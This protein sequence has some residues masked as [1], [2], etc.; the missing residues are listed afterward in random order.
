[1]RECGAGRDHDRRQVAG[2]T[3]VLYHRLL[4]GREGGG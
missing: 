2:L 1:M 4:V 3:L